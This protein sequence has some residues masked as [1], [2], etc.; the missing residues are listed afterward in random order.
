MMILDVGCGSEPKGDVN[1]ARYSTE[2]LFL[3]NAF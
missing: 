3:Q 2:R 1:I